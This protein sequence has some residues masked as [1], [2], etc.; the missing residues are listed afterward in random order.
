MSQRALGDTST[1]A[2]FNSAFTEVANGGSGYDAHSASRSSG[3]SGGFGLGAPG[4]GFGGVL[5]FGGSDSSGSSNSNGSTSSY[6]NGQRDAG[7]NAVADP[8]EL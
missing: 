7:D 3:T 4:S 8:G 6:L 1:T 5:G 2:T